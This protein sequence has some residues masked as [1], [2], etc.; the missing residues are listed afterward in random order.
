[1]DVS[2]P[3]TKGVIMWGKMTTSRMGIMGNNRV[4]F[5]SRPEN[6]WGPLTC[7]LKE[8]GAEVDFVVLHHLVGHNEFAN[9]AL[10]GKVVHQ[11]QH[12]VFQNHA[13]PTGTHLSFQRL[14][15]NCTEALLAEPQ[16]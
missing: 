2:R 12:Q 14:G 4:S 13:Q 7:F 15:G 10:A 5:F 16:L 1:M 6:I 9:L 11:V 8:S 3:T